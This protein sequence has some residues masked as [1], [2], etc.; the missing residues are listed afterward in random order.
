MQVLQQDRNHVPTLAKLAAIELDL[1]HLEAAETNIT[2]AV[3]LAPD[4][5]FSQFVLG[6]LR[7]TQ[8]K[9]DEAIDALGRAAKLDPRDA[10]IQN[11]LGLALSEKGLRGPAETALR[12]AV[13]LD[14]SYANAH[15]NLAVVYVTQQ[16]PLVELARWHYQKALAAGLSRNPNLE[17]M[18]EAKQAAASAP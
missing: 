10:Q 13:Q 16:P 4:D 17:K 18:I 8:A 7:F 15:H 12:K 2:Q 6:R 5:A 3:T 9:Y 1:N 14:P 11:F